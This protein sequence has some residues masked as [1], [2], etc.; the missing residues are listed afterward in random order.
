MTTARTYKWRGARQPEAVTPGGL[1]R[2]LHLDLLLYPKPG[3]RNRWVL[4]VC[5][6]RLRGRIERL[7]PANPA[8]WEDVDLDGVPTTCYRMRRR[9]IDHLNE[10]PFLLSY[11]RFSQA[12]GS[13]VVRECFP[14][15]WMRNNNIRAR[16]RNTWEA[17]HGGIR[18]DKFNRGPSVRACARMSIT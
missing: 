11:S 6:A 14:E 9:Q 8:C 10:G 12:L 16:A 2:L 18:A 1:A 13:R 3:A 7:N 5:A 4:P 15:L 17:H